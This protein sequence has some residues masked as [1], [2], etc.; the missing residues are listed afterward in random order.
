MLSVI[1]A[2]RRDTF[3]FQRDIAPVHLLYQEMSQF[4]SAELWPPCNGTDVTDSVKV[5]RLTRSKI[6]NFGDVLPSQ[7]LGLALKKLNLTQQ[8]QARMWDNPERDGR[9]A[10]YR[11]RPLFNIAKFGWGPLLECRAVTL[12]RRKT[13]WNVLRWPKLANRSQPLGRISPYCEDMW[14]RHCWLRSF[15]RLSIRAFIANT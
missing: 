7:S 2:M 4:I 10:Q 1:A 14:G 9:P 12:K 11:W 6:D 13:R 15:F 5:L 3:I 8:R